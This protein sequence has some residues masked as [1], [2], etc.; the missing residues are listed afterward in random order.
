MTIQYVVTELCRE[1][2]EHVKYLKFDL[3][4]GKPF[5]YRSRTSSNAFFHGA[6]EYNKSQKFLYIGKHEREHQIMIDVWKKSMAKHPELPDTYSSV[7]VVHIKNL[8]EFY[9]LI[10]YDY[11][12]KK[13]YE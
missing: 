10:G 6:K 9:N 2:C 4:D 1:T 3:D 8:W 7:P 13:Y 11:K 5:C 12:R